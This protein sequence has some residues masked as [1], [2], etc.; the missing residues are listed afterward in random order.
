MR[1]IPAGR[2]GAALLLAGALLAP[3]QAAADGEAPAHPH[4]RTH[5]AYHPFA[6]PRERHVIEVVRHAYST[7]FI[8]NGLPFSG[9]DACSLGWIAGQRVEL[10]AGSWH[11]ICQEAVFYNVARRQSCALSCPSAAARFLSEH[12]L[13]PFPY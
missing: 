10:R 11:G 6:L 12:S 9:R 3:A 7:D 13:H 5:F 8:I 1:S 4:Y 2:T